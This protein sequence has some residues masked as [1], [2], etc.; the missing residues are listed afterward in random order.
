MKNQKVGYL[1]NFHLQKI[2]E[3]NCKRFRRKKYLA[4]IWFLKK[5]KKKNYIVIS[6]YNIEF[7]KILEQRR[8]CY[9]TTLWFR[10]W[11]WNFPSTTTLR[12]LGPKPWRTAYVQPS[13]R[14]T[15]GRYGDN[16]NRLQHYYQ[17]QVLIKPSPEEYKKTIFK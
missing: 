7:T 11:G 1:K 2:V 9:I 12:S 14:P 10:S 8:L 15:D 17:F 5:K 3:K 4:K 16:P 6:R 13:R